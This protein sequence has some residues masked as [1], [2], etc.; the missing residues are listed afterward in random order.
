MPLATL[1]GHLPV[2]VK[3]SLNGLRRMK[4]PQKGAVAGSNRGV[5][6]WR[7]SSSDDHYLAMQVSPLVQFSEGLEEAQI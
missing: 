1:S 6:R 3:L 2:N 5:V 7:N 4:R